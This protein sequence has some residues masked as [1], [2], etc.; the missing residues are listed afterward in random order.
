MLNKKSLISTG[1]LALA[2]MTV[3]SPAMAQS[4]KPVNSTTKLS[5]VLNLQQSIN[6]NCN[7]HVDVSING[8]G[9]ATVT[10]R[11]FSPGSPLCGGVVQP[12]G[13]WTLTPNSTTQ[14]TATVGASSVLGSCVGSV[15]G[16]WNNANSTLTFNN[17][18]VPGT[19]GPCTVNGTLTANPAVTI[20]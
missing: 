9:V 14:V 8:S 18:T 5:G 10:S 16:A 11:S 20:H 1:A 19:P 2:A 12:F 6:I 17:A 15:I 3:A 4:F 7:V 13:T